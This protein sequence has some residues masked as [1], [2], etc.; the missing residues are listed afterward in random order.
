[1][2]LFKWL[3]EQ[4]IQLSS[5]LRTIQKAKTSRIEVES[6]VKGII[7]FFHYNGVYSIRD[8][9]ELNDLEKSFIKSMLRTRSRQHQIEV[10]FHL[11]LELANKQQLK[12]MLKMYEEEENYEKCSVI[13]KKIDS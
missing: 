13:K 9:H 11:E 2:I 12:R 8:Y 3:N 6:D 1:V 7:D 4:Y 10:E 5:Y